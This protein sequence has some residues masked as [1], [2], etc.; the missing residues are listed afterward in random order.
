MIRI[1]KA[2]GWMRWR[3][4]MNSLE[5]GGTRDRLE[6]FSVALEQ[7]GPIIAILLLVPSAIFFAG[8][9]AYAGW[10]LA[11]GNP[12]P[13]V[14]EAL[15]FLLIFVCAIT[16]FGPFILPAG[17][18]TNTVRLLLLPIPR[19]T[20]YVAQ[21]ASA[22]SDP[23]NLLTIPVLV[24]IAL[25]L[26]AGGALLS[27]LV[28]AAA[29]AALMAALLGITALITNIVQLVVR[30]RRRGELFALVFILVF[31]LLGFLPQIVESGRRHD[32]DRPPEA[33][34]ERRRRAMPVWW[35]TAQRTVLAVVPSEMYVR[36]TRATA[37]GRARDAVAPAA[38]LAAVATGLHAFGLF[39]FGRVLASPGVVTARRSSARWT[40]GGRRIPGVP[41]RV[42]AVALAQ[43]R[44]GFRTP[45]GRSTLLSPVVVFVMFALMIA[46]SGSQFQEEL[47]FLS[48][49]NGLSLASFGAF[50]S[51]VAIL[52]L[53]M[54]QFAI[55]GSGLT[56]VFLSPIKDVELLLGKA[57]GNWLV[58]SGPAALCIIAS[59]LLFP[60][61]PL[62]LWLS[63]PLALI[64]TY[65][66]VAP[67]AAVVSAMFPKAV[68]L[69]SIG[70]GSN[71]HGA[72]GLLGLVTF[73]AAAMPPA[74]IV[75]VAT[76]MLER[77]ALAPLLLTAWCVAAAGLSWLL[78]R[79]ARR[80]LA[81]RRENLGLTAS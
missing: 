33:R 17:E 13:M 30:N 41:R 74:A 59:Y 14:F 9:G 55:D 76:N 47:D 52:P 62:S 2:F 48:L 53:A 67:V 24:S 7:L 39:A 66:I 38:A 78:F 81:A 5:R 61:G 80:V 73:L 28:A 12:R 63:I 34:V 79:V 1:L 4:L 54:N 11:T 49:G 26:A 60:G 21:A 69:N 37:T 27:A 10:A 50:V 68:D 44:L 56:L 77:P 57:L 32:P 58:L 71:A 70:R 31:P 19:P 45:R 8:A 20:L 25:G 43:A 46:R 75:F 23:W 16:V 29:G 3:I 15:R 36:A 18:R 35:N 22:L 40:A 65:A 6:R 42:S 51:L 72:A 64:G